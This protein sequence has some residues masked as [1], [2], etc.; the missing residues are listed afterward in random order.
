[1]HPL[2]SHLSLLSLTQCHPL[3]SHLSLLSLTQ[4]HPLPSHLSLFPH[5]VSS[6]PFTP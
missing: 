5:P 3:P 4:C 6:S 1:S 2:P